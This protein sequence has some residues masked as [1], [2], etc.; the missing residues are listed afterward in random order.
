M[1]TINPDAAARSLRSSP[2]PFELTPISGSPVTGGGN[3]SVMVG[4]DAAAFERQTA[5]RCDQPK[6]DAI[7]ATQ[8]L[9]CR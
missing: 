4:G 5:T 1:S 2:S 9:L 7:G 3:A 6:G 8:L